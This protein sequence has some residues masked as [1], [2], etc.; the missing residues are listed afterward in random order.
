[1]YPQPRDPYAGKSA[2]PAD[3]GAGVEADPLPPITTAGPTLTT[4]TTCMARATQPTKLIEPVIVAIT[5]MIDLHRASNATRRRAPPA[6]LAPTHHIARQHRRP[7]LRSPVHRQPV[8]STR[9]RPR[10][11]PMHRARRPV[12][13]AILRAGRRCTHSAP[14]GNGKRT[15]PPGRS[16]HN[17][18][19]T[20]TDAAQRVVDTRRTPSVQPLPSCSDRRYDE[21]GHRA[22]VWRWAR[23]AFA[24]VSGVRAARRESRQELHTWRR[25][26]RPQSAHGVE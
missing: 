11:P 16:P 10:P 19:G 20:V 23:R 22:F 15:P 1:M 2:V 21:H 4:R 18:R 13:A 24:P 26:G 8:T 3:G 6:S 14:P 7:Q 12:G 9:T 5:G 17:L 25:V